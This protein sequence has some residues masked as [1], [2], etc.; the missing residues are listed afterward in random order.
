[1]TDKI[2]R[3]K[4]EFRNYLIIKFPNTSKSTIDTYIL[5]AFYV[6]R[7]NAKFDINFFDLFKSKEDIMQ[8]KPKLYN[9]QLS[10]KIKKPKN[11]TSAYVCG[12][13]RLYD[14]FQER[15]GSVENFINS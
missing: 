8:F 1:M 14:F 7:H 11:S 13:N 2:K 15:Y 10:R 3:L 5:D 6:Y 4:N 12:L 9:Q